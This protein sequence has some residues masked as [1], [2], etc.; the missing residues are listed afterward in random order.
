M[1]LQFSAQQATQLVS[2]AVGL[3]GAAKELAL[4][5]EMDPELAGACGVEISALE[6]R[7]L[8]SGGALDRIVQGSSTAAREGKPVA[9]AAEDV[10]AF[11]RLEAVV[12]LGSSRINLKLASMEAEASQEGLAKWGGLLGLATGAIGLIKSF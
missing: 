12:A 11:G 10:E 1:N 8:L 4:F 2:R 3:A 6:A 9:L 7:S 5:G